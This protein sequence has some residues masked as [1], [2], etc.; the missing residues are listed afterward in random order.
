[1]IIILK[2]ETRKKCLAI[3]SN[4]SKIL[5]SYEDLVDNYKLVLQ[6]KDLSIRPDYWGGFIVEP[7]YFEFWEGHQNRLNKRE[8]FKLNQNIWHK[9]LLWP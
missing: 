6:E 2:I 5:T 4:Q 7:Y 9:D 1:M 3:C 8:C